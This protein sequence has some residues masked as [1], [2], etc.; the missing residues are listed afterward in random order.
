MELVEHFIRCVRVSYDRFVPRPRESLCA[1]ALTKNMIKRSHRQSHSCRGRSINGLTNTCRRGHIRL[2]RHRSTMFKQRMKAEKRMSDFFSLSRE[3]VRL[4]HILVAHL[5]HSGLKLR[6]NC[7]SGAVS[8]RIY[9]P[10]SH[11]TESAYSW[12]PRVFGVIWYRCRRISAPCLK[13]VNVNQVS[14]ERQPSL[15]FISDL[16]L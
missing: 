7:V 3:T 15:S 16:I 2:S 8:T 10:A 12:M 14:S 5:C 9:W 1:R 4:R 11:E 6:R 13:H